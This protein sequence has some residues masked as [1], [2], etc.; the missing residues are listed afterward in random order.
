MTTYAFRD[1]RGDVVH[2]SPRLSMPTPA[3]ALTP[4]ALEA[5]ESVR[6]LGH[7]TRLTRRMAAIVTD[8][9]NPRP[10]PYAGP[11]VT[12]AAR[13][14]VARAERAGFTVTLTELD[15]GCHVDGVHRARG[16]GFRAFWERGKTT[17]GSWHEK[18]ERYTLIE[19]DRPVGVHKIARVG[20]AGK[21]AAGVERVH[22]KL[23][24][25]PYG[26]PCSITEIERRI[27]A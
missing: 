17:G 13:S 23:I 1:E 16:V 3:H 5:V 24:A 14:L 26:I 20:L 25:S 4:A 21:R 27:D 8:H 7:Q 19:D 18:R 22:L 12:A 9:G 10:K 15:A 6:A 2:T 11:S